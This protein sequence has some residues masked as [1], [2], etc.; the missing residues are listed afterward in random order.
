MRPLKL[1]MNAFGPYAGT[2]VLDF[3]TLSDSQLFLIHGPTGGGKSTLLDAICY[4]LYGESSS[5]ERDGESLRS[6]HAAPD[7]LTEVE[8][9]FRVGSRKFRIKRSPKQERPALRGDGMVAVQP[10]V[11]MWAL[12][13][14]DSEA[15]V[16]ASKIGEV[17]NKVTELLGFESEQFRQVIMLPQGKFR[18]LLLADS[19]KREAILAQLFDTHIYSRIEKAL[20]ERSLALKRNVEKIIDRQK[21][22]LDSRGCTNRDELNDQRDQAAQHITEQAKLIEPFK[23][24]EENAKNR[25][26]KADELEKKFLRVEN[27][28]RQLIEQNKKT[29]QIETVRKLLAAAVAADKLS[30]LYAQFDGASESLKTAAVDHKAATDTLCRAEELLNEASAAKGRAKQDQSAVDQLKQQQ[31]KLIEFRPRLTQFARTA[32]ELGKAQALAEAAGEAERVLAERLNGLIEEQEHKE[33]RLRAVESERE[34]GKGLDAEVDRAAAIV[35]A[36]KKLEDV[37]ARKKSATEELTRW[38][39]R[40]QEAEKNRSKARADLGQL[41]AAR[42]AGQAGVLAQ[43]LADGEP[44]PVCGSVDHPNPATV[45]EELPGNEQIETAEEAVAAANDAYDKATTGRSEATT[46]LKLEEQ[47]ENDLLVSLAAAAT[48]SIASLQEEYTA[49]IEKQGAQKK[50]SEELTELREILPKL[51]KGVEQSRKTLDAA[52]KKTAT[53]K[54]ALASAK[55]LYDDHKSA[56]PAKYSSA[57]I[58]EEDIATLKTQLEVLV[59]RIESADSAYTTAVKDHAMAQTTKDSTSRALS[60]AEREHET[61]SAKWQARRSE[62]GFESDKD[63]VSSRLDNGKQAVYESEIGG[64]DKELQRLT[65]LL[66]QARDDVGG[67]ERPDVQQLTALH[68]NAS[69]AREKAESQLVMM[70]GTAKEIDSII[71]K[72]TV[73]DEEREKNEAEYGVLGAISDLANGR[74][75]KGITFQRFVLAA[76]LDDVLLAATERLDKMSKGRY[77][78]TRA[79]ERRDARSAGGLDLMVEDGYT[80]RTRPVATLSG[81][82][83][84]QAALSL[85]LGLADVV[86]SY[87]GGVYLDTIFIDE[88]FGSL[89][90][91]SLDLA[92]N[93]LIDLRKSGRMV[94]V[95]SHV[96]ELKDRIDVR[97]QV[98]SGRDGSKA[99]FVMP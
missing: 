80:G 43:A 98:D 72:L 68:K 55:S 67:K 88:G 6:H 77:R 52:C 8:L 5:A 18:D 35:D 74:N 70:Q 63:F 4:A 39:M 95:I 97:L 45:S 93:T 48:K 60:K 81:G 65:T 13:D 92:I 89:D 32:S 82:E 9:D 20:K 84:F 1:T 15:E 66:Q 49:L 37:L 53:A 75:P 47:A 7:H 76:L 90:V 78:L 42:L 34:K 79:D 28:E 59:K 44:C 38:E 46:A 69:A 54:E 11:A 50:L 73:S 24:K 17:H 86:Q 85:A 51:K 56:L 10:A 41:E 21:G 71:Q 33:L 3:S 96:A 58:L 14:D 87:A 16:L 64:F 94:G 40:L 22:L 99:R 2:Q 62:A 19:K 31:T 27:Q 26:I 30:D 23:K 29:E 83:S 57:D 12:K 36:K 61:L 91:E 25:L